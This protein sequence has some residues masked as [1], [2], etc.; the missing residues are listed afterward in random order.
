MAGP[1][2][3]LD[4]EDATS[5][6]SAVGCVPTEAALACIVK[7]PLLMQYR[8]SSAACM[9]LVCGELRLPAVCEA[10]HDILLCG[11]GQF[12]QAIIDAARRQLAHFGELR[13]KRLDDAVAE[14]VADLPAQYDGVSIAGLGLKFRCAKCYKTTALL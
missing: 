13:L 6:V 2:V 5:A 1:E 3:R 11:N 8:L 12:L 10:L 9:Q 7:E 14:A 4:P